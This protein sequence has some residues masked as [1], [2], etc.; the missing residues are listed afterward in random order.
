[1]N[2]GETLVHGGG[3]HRAALLGGGI[4]T[5][6]YADLEHRSGRVAAAIVARTA[7]GDRVGIVIP[8]RVEFVV[9]YLA[10]LRAGRV[11]VP[12]NPA[13]PA[14]A[15]DSELAAV[16]AA[17]RLDAAAVV[18][19]EANGAGADFEPT[20]A[21]AGATAVCLFTSGT[22]GAPKAAMLTHGSLLANLEQVASVP[23]LALNADDIALGV[24]PL[25]H[26]YGLNGVLGCALHQGAAVLL[27]ETFQPIAVAAEA[28]E[29]GVTMLAG[30]PAVYSAFLASDIA[31]DT[32]AN[33]RLAVSG[34]A[35]LMQHVQ[36]EFAQRFG[37]T[38]HDGYGLT[39]ASPIVS[40]TAVDREIRP[41]SI[42]PPLPGVEVRLVGEDGEDALED[43]PGEIW[44]R[45]P[46]VFA[47]YWNDPQQTAAVLTADGW[48]RTGDVAVA[49][50]DGWLTLV[51]RAKD[52]I[53]VSGFNV[54]PAEVEDALL[55]LDDVGEAAVIGEPD[56][57]SG[58]RVV[59][60]VVPL[61][62][63][64]PPTATQLIAHLRRR[65]ARYKI[66]AR[67][68]IVDTLPHTV[69]GKVMRRALRGI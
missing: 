31:A 66:P 18:E 57:R 17:L 41:G 28:R 65:I 45:G 38:V 53:I 11:A 56:E 39:E 58:E 40:T 2:L 3:A 16:G 32:F 34:A 21:A 35:P 33:V 46:N 50:D 68:E 36:T 25:F 26:V 22:A 14:A 55:E 24:L 48:L 19:L 4:G 49:D 23:R 27:I 20:D 61:E 59:A 60:Y 7:P 44:V 5:T 64:E 42:G 62:G 1:V 15:I 63:A 51:D 47:G 12:I 43:D 30:V 67:F 6:S 69:T 52:L 29:G 13:S 9:A 8:N 37:V 10:A 54:Y